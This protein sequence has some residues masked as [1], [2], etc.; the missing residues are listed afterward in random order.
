M[1][2]RYNQIV[3][4]SPT[5]PDW[6]TDQMGW[7]VV[8]TIQVFKVVNMNTLGPIE[9]LVMLVIAVA[10]IGIPIATLILVVLIYRKL[11]R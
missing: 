8:N 11:N 5:W 9:L 10:T 7:G 6:H 3:R 1:A 2:N 4:A